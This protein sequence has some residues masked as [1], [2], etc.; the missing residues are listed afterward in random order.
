MKFHEVIKKDGLSTLPELLIEHPF[1]KD[2]KSSIELGTSIYMNS[3][4]YRTSYEVP[5]CSSPTYRKCVFLGKLRMRKLQ[6]IVA[7]PP[8]YGKERKTFEVTMAENGENPYKKFSEAFSFVWLTKPL[9]F[10]IFSVSKTV[11]HSMHVNECCRGAIIQREYYSVHSF[12]LFSAQIMKMGRVNTILNF[13][14]LRWQRTAGKNN[15]FAA[16][17]EFGLILVDIIRKVTHTVQKKL[18]I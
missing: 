18:S 9:C 14:R 4:A 7:F 5:T 8:I 2:C 13:A 16:A 3:S 12:E 6:R 1:W 17:R 15:Q 11:I 10:K